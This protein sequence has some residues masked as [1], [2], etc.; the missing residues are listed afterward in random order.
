MV[1]RASQAH[2]MP[3]AGLPQSMPV[4]R[5]MPDVDDG[6]F[7]GGDGEGVGG[8]GLEG[9]ATAPEEEGERGDEVDVGKDEAEDRVR[10]VVVEDALQIAHR[11]LGGGEED[12][13]TEAD[14]E[15]GDGRQNQ[16]QA[17]LRR[18]EERGHYAAILS[19]K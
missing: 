18:M 19:R 7:G 14:D 6:D 10:H 15:D 12:G 11:R 4:T 5:Q 3:Q 8:E 17:T 9:I 2:Q 1:R 13:L 16:S